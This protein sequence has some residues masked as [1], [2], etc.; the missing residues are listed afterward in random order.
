MP[1]ARLHYSLL[2][3]HANGAGST[4][5][6]DFEQIVSANAD[7]QPS[8]LPEMRELKAFNRT[9]KERVETDGI[10]AELEAGEAKDDDLAQSAL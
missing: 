4:F 6:L 5:D 1:L 3:V 7:V 9:G 10:V 2:P 8:S